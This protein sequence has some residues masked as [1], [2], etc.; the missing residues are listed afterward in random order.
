MLRKRVCIIEGMGK[1]IHSS[2]D[3]GA[4]LKNSS[5]CNHAGAASVRSPIGCTE[6]AKPQQPFVDWCAKERVLFP[7]C[8]IKNLPLTGRAVVAARDIL[9]NEVVVEVPDAAVLM[10]ENCGIADILE[11]GQ[12]GPCVAVGSRARAYPPHVCTAACMPCTTGI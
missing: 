6:D 12:A 4:K 5:S 1:P 2:S 3:K 10:V 11:G 8:A 7:A 9:M